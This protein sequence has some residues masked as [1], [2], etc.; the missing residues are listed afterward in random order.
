[1]D[2]DTY[3]ARFLED[4]AALS[5]VEICEASGLTEDELRELVD[6]GVLAPQRPGELVFAAHA[7]VIARE[8]HRVRREFALDD[9][10]SVCIVL[11]L[12]ERVQSL[13]RELSTLRARIGIR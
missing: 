12:F 2:A 4:F 3:E 5:V 7:L 1:M 8:A 11:R 13:E 9:V 6:E 10:H